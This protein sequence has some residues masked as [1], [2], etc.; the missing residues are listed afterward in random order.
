MVLK[1]I[2]NYNKL[3]KRK[4]EVLPEWKRSVNE[5]NERYFLWLE[6]FVEFMIPWLVLLLLVIIIAEFSEVINIFRWHWLDSLGEFAHAHDKEVVMLDRIIVT[7]FVIDLYFSFFKKSTLWRFIKHYFLDIL[8]VFPFGLFI[9]ASAVAESQE[10]LH[11]VGE[12]EKEVS[13]LTRTERIAAAFERFL[14]RA[15]RFFRVFGR[16]ARVLRIYRLIDLFKQKNKKKQK[17]KQKKK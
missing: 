2:R 3:R 4:D 9:G 1:H 11:V 7:F 8:A 16:L 12:T 17:N 15:G 13:K 10:I 6:K 14:A 5:F